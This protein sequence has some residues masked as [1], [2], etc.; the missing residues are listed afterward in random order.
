MMKTDK[1]L[2]G[3]IEEIIEGK[4]MIITFQQPLGFYKKVFEL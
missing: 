3:V 1:S 2:E 4:K